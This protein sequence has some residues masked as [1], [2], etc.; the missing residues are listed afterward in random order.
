MV[1]GWGLELDMLRTYLQK[2]VKSGR[3]TVLTPT[4]TIMVGK[5]DE[6]FPETSL[7][8]A[9]RIKNRATAVK[10]ALNPDLRLGEAYADG[11]LVMERGSVWDLLQIVGFN[12]SEPEL[13][14]SRW[15]R[16]ATKAMNTV[17]HR[18]GLKVS[19][20]NVARHYDLSGSMYRLFLDED[21][22]YSCAYFRTPDASLEQAQ[23]AK[24][25]HV[26]AKLLLRP[27][28]RVLDIGCG[29]GGLALSIARSENVEVL[30]ITLSQE[31][32]AVA[33]E[34]AQ[35][36]GLSDRVQFQLID[37]RQL[38]GSFDRIVS[39]GMFEHVGTP[40][41]QTFFGQVRR[42]LKPDGIGVLH[43]IGKLHGP[44]PTNPWIRKHIFP[45]GYI[46]A[47]SEVLPSLE[48]SGLFLTDVEILRLHYAD[49]LRAWRERFLARQ[50]ELA[51][52]YDER[53]RRMWEFYL[54]GSEMSFRYYGFMVF[55]IQLSRS[56]GAVPLTR[57]YMIE[58]EARLRAEANQT[59]DAD[60]SAG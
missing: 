60:A 40:Q 54:A 55:Q 20:R 12:S 52:I 41:Y 5:L 50:S 11:D 51:E 44:A 19:R 39:V 34:R 35:A 42:L 22:Q 18:N 25:Q 26:A 24:K 15:M 2:L 4:D 1:K 10:L 47:L 27:G 57:D 28:Q 21:M 33:R 7:D 37:Y 49:T 36:A 56:L 38:E 6:R 23:V 53:F 46:P 32:L 16:L 59:C 13:T 8:V 43:S 58:A 30:G 9:V 17:L 29:W 31:Q 3:L 14:S 48:Q 45:G